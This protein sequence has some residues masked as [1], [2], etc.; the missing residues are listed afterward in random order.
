LACEAALKHCEEL[1]MDTPEDQAVV[2][3]LAD[4]LRL[5]LA[6]KP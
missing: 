3:K 6:V 5:A 4:T 2:D 1:R